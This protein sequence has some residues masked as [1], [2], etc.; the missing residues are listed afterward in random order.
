MT[1]NLST[2]FVLLC[3]LLCTALF[4]QQK[5][6]YTDMRDGK[7]YKTTKIGKQ[8]WMAE[9]LNYEMKG[10]KCYDNEPVNCQIY[11]RLYDWNMA[12][13]ACPKG[14]HLPTEANFE[15]LMETVNKSPKFLKAT[16]GWNDFKGSEEIPGNGVDI[17]GFSALPGGAG[18]SD[19]SFY[20]GGK[21]GYWWHASLYSGV[22]F[23]LHI[24]NNDKYTLN[25]GNSKNS[26]FYSVR[27]IQN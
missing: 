10:S 5:G 27:C 2:I 25:S 11:G 12:I 26:S 13:K 3:T 6:T 17:Y 23:Y 7:I 9:N 1:N 19:G 8:I 20:N 22:A 16:S 24:K 15:A 14:W 21:E 18:W 4:A